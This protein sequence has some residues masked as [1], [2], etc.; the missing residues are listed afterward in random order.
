MAEVDSHFLLGRHVFFGLLII[1]DIEQLQFGL[2]LLQLSRTKL[3]L[4]LRVSPV[5]LAQFH[6]LISVLEKTLKLASYL[7]VQMGLTLIPYLS[8]SCL[9]LVNRCLTH[10]ICVIILIKSAQGE[11][12]LVSSSQSRLT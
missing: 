12:V 3:L 5:V 2:H 1:V 10:A 6:Q 11:R 9:D 7:H 4:P 8:F